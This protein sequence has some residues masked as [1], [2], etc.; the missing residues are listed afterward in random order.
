MTIWWAAEWAAT[1]HPRCGFHRRSI[2]VP[3]D[4]DLNLGKAH[5]EVGRIAEALEAEA[6]SIKS[7]RTGA[8]GPNYEF[9]GT[10]LATPILTFPICLFECTWEREGSP[11]QSDTIDDMMGGNF[12]LPNT[13]DHMQEGRGLDDLVAAH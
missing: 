2:G 1:K 10:V 8:E 5:L 13:S 4:T 6:P 11:V 12:R 9:T 3:N 7:F